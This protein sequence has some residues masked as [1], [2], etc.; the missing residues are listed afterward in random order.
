MSISNEVDSLPT[1]DYSSFF[2]SDPSISTTAPSGSLP[3]PTDSPHATY[4]P[5]TYEVTSPTLTNETA[6]PAS[7]IDWQAA[8][9]PEVSAAN[10]GGKKVGTGGG[11]G[12]KRKSDAMNAG[13]GGSPGKEGT[14]K[15]ARK[16][17]N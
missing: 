14:R 9:T 5:K 6:S 11:G 4:Q 7:E 13:E 8:Q 2:S 17:K 10:V 16:K 3:F 1:M 12:R 15:S